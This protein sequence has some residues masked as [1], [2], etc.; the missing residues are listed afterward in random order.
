GLLATVALIPYIYLIYQ[1]PATLDEQQTLISTH[2]CDLLR[3]HELIGT[4]ILLLIV[5]GVRRRKIKWTQPQ[6]LYAASLAVLPFIVFNQQVLTGKAM[7]SF[8]FEI[9]A[10]NYST[11]VGLLITGVLLRNLSRRFLVMTA[12]LSVL[13]GFMVVAIP[14]R[15]VFVP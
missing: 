11:M 7:Q 10:V 13:W 6:V 14:S 4:V 1:R 8:H 2:R 9:F 5:V 3:V 15:L 12:G